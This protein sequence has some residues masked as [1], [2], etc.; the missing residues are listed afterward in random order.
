MRLHL[1]Q[2]EKIISRCI[3][4][5]EEVFPGDNKW[6]IMPNSS[7][8]DF[9]GE[10]GGVVKCEYGSEVFNRT[11]GD[12]SKYD[13][14]IIHF[15]TSDSAKF[16]CSIEHPSVYWIEWGADL[17][18]EL[19]YLKGF[20]LYEN[21]YK[22]RRFSRFGWLGPLYPVIQKRRK[23]K[24][25]KLFLEAAKK[26]KYF[27]P[28]S[29]Y[30]EYPMLLNYYPEL[31]HLEYKEFFYYPINEVLGAGYLDRYTKANNIILGNSASLTGNHYEVLDILSK[32]D[33]H[34]RKIIIPLSYGSDAYANDVE[35]FGRTRLGGSLCTLREYMPLDKYNEILESANVFIYNNYRQEAVGNILV[36]LFL[37]GKVFLNEKNPLLPFYKRLGLEIYPLGDLNKTGGLDTLSKE[38]VGKNREILMK[39]YSRERQLMLIKANM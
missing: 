9:I 26:M 2:N 11:V 3:D 6:I 15:L 13:K 8:R 39:H 32:I 21:E 14:I 7:H 10:R 4:N 23:K 34:D 22:L 31:K 18:N 30:D 33:L 37:G 35:T 24:R 38:A 20:P 1:A 17:Y 28:D 27:V 5:F 16:V 19:L 12:V 29:M 36:A 25:Q